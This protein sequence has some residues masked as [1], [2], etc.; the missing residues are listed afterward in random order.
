MKNILSNY[1]YFIKE[2]YKH[3]KKY[4]IYLFIMILLKSIS[5]FILVIFPKYI[6]NEIFG[7]SRINIILIYIAAMG[8]VSI[9][10]NILINFFEPK[11]SNQI[12]H[13]RTKLSLNL[14]NYILNMDYEYMEMPEIIDKKQKAIEFI[15]SGVG[16]DSFTFSAETMISSTIQC[17]GYIYLLF[18]I[19]PFIIFIIISL[20]IINAIFQSKT[21][22]YSYQAEMEIVRPNRRGSYID[23]ICS[24]FGFVKEIK[25]YG[26]INWILNKKNYYNE[27]KLKAFDKVCNKFVFLGVVS[28]TLNTLSNM[29][30]YLYLVWQLF[31][32]KILI[33]DFTMYLSSINNFSNSISVIFSSFVKFSQVNRYLDNYIEFKKLKNKINTLESKINIKNFDKYEI[34]FKNV[35]F[36]Y[37]GQENYVLKNISF[38]IHH[39][40][41]ISIVGK[42][43]A[44][45]T[46]FIKLLMRLYDPSEGEIL[47]NGINIKQINYFDYINLFSVVFQ[48]FKLFAFTIKENIMLDK[49]ELTSD[50]KCNQ[51]LNEVGL[52]SKINN[53]DKGIH[54]GIGKQFD[55][56][57]IELS[58]GESQ[59]LAISKAIFK[60]SP[61]VIL[62]EP[63]SALD[64]LAEYEIYKNFDNLVKNKTSIYISHRLSSTRF[65]D[66]IIVLDYGKILE[67]GNHDELI[68]LNG[69]Y[70]E[71]FEKQSHFYVESKSGI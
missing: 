66:T 26:I 53:L 1:I 67:V 14:S 31:G 11:L 61:I 69:T 42:N 6:L 48:D 55:D 8:L 47:L 62:D 49:S 50:D 19:N 36:K 51:I 63:T 15:Y 37:P 28:T 38:K 18:L 17:I 32:G 9:T 35:S 10:I 56:N 65:S 59:K 25:I 68:K 13:L 34:E 45:K 33:G 30:V 5:P 64:P 27:I 39:G 4:F 7:Q 57:G 54:T 2:T 29:L 3:D 52:G 40:E 71:M 22:K 20:S 21:E 44:G 58:G 43:G 16:I 60:D 12:Q 46:T 70:K 24:D 41:R 23:Y